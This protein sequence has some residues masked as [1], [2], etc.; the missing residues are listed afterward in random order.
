MSSFFYCSVKSYVKIWAIWGTS[1]SVFFHMMWVF[2]RSSAV[3]CQVCFTNTQQLP[4]TH[5]YIRTHTTTR[6][7]STHSCLNQ[8]SYHRSYNKHLTSHKTLKA[9]VRHFEKCYTIPGRALWLWRWGTNQQDIRFWWISCKMCSDRNQI[10]Q[11]PM[12]QL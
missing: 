4:F 9:I 1:M 5:T 12:Y 10:Y 7:L 6:F 3:I 11:Q 2:S 8:T